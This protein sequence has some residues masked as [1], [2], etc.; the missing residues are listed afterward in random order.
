MM[1]INAGIRT[2]SGM[3]FFTNEITRLDITNTKAV[4]APIPNPFIAEEVTPKVGHNPN[5]ITNTGFS[6][7]I[8]F[9]KF[10][11]RLVG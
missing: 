6:F 8:P 5:K 4:A 3:K 2:L 10:S 11:F 7:M 9:R 1:T